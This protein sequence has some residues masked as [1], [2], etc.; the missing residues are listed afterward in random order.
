MRRWH[1]ALATGLACAAVLAGVVA[2][3][4][5]PRGGA[6][7]AGDT[8]QERTV[9]F[10]VTP[11]GD[12]I[13]RFVIARDLVCRRG[14]RRTGLTGHFRQRGARIE[15]RR[16][17]RFHAEPRVEG[18]GQS[19]ISGGRVCIRGS[20]YRKGRI[21]RGRYREVVRLRDGSLCRSGLVKFMARVR[22]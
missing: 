10:K 19:K 13:K 9:R 17:G 20:F 3:A 15:L 12:L 4:S 7:Y 1:L 18:G 2:A 6:R 14:K 5:P 16:N 8:S 22:G 21:M 11:D